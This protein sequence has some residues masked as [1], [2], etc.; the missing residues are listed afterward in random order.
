MEVDGTQVERKQA[1]W[2]RVRRGQGVRQ[3]LSVA[4]YNFRGFLKNPKVILTFLLGF[5][6]CYFLSTRVMVVIDAYGTPVQFAEPFLWTFGDTTS[7]L[8]SSLLL[9]LLFSDLPR[10]SSVTPYYL[11]R[12]TKRRWLA[13]QLLYVAAVTLIYVLYLFLV[14]A[15]LCMRVSYL[16]NIWSDTAAM[17]GYSKLGEELSVPSTVK[18]M[19]SITPYECMAQVLLL[20]FFYILCLSVLILAGNLLLGS[21]RGMILGLLFSLYGFLLEPEVLGKLLGL[22]PYEMYRIN[23]AIGWISPLS[24]VTY[25]K[26][27][28]GYDRLPTVQQSC[29][30]FLAL[31][32]L[33]GALAARALRGYSFRF[34]GERS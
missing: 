25:A 7:I 5:V 9:L 1:E 6:L 3:I 20:L 30:V 22:A 23:V 31:L 27:N 15:V 21:N 11:Y 29:L 34:L 28:F 32:V 18:V 26:H 8:L 13:G 4:G 24:H 19:E 12:T 2:T 17:L 16:G 10:M 33:S 14:T